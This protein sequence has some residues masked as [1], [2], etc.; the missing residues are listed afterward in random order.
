MTVSLADGES[1]I[2][3]ALR[4]TDQ[5]N[6]RSKFAGLVTRRGVS[7]SNTESV[8]LMRVELI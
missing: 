4:A 2:I 6:D 1:R 5:R 7:Q 8:L 3:T